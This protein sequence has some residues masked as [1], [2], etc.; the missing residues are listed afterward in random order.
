MANPQSVPIR[1]A[2]P[3][4]QLF[5]IATIERALRPMT[6]LQIAEPIIPCFIARSLTSMTRL[7]SRNPKG[8][9]YCRNCTAIRLIPWQR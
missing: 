7:F 1:Q 2:I 4:G 9:S 5:P 6:N 3:S 8:R